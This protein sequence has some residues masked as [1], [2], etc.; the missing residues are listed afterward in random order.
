[1]QFKTFGLTALLCIAQ[2]ALAFPRVSPEEFNRIL[3]RADTSMMPDI[4]DGQIGRV[5]QY[6]P[7]PAFTGTKQIPGKLNVFIFE[8]PV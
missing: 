5:V 6:D 4:R 7:V 1:M 8:L 3:E 2:T